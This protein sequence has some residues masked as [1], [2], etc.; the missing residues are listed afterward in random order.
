[1]GRSQHL[2]V[3]PIEWLV[4]MINIAFF[5]VLAMLMDLDRYR[6]EAPPCAQHPSPGA[7]E[8]E[9]LSPALGEIVPI[10]RSYEPSL[11]NIAKARVLGFAENWFLGK[12]KN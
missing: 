11:P 2:A 3:V 6:L 12:K 9:R 1:M 5:L 8:R 7:Q 10:P 4:A